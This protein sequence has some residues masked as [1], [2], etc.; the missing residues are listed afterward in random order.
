M[1]AKLSGVETEAIRVLSS[2]FTVA[3]GTTI[4]DRPP[5]GSVRAALPHTALA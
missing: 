4:T 3:V 1:A 2:L 5:R